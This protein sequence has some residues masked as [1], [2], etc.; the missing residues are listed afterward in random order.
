MKQYEDKHLFY[1]RTETISNFIAFGI[2]HLKISKQIDSI[3]LYR[4]TGRCISTLLIDR[5]T[6]FWNARCCCL[7]FTTFFSMPIISKTK[8][9][10]KY[11]SSD[12]IIKVSSACFVVIVR[13]PFFKLLISNR[14]SVQLIDTNL[15]FWIIIFAIPDDGI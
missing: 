10:Q 11:D 8:N 3:N 1:F 5:Y 9:Q 15:R 4:S 13:I 2:E 12:Y 14:R 7:L 6:I